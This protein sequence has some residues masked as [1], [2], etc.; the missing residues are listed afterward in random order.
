MARLVV[1]DFAPLNRSAHMMPMLRALK[2]AESGAPIRDQINQ[3]PPDM[4]RRA[5]RDGWSQP[6]EGLAPVPAFVFDDLTAHWSANATTV[7]DSFFAYYTRFSADQDGT[8]CSSAYS[9][10]V[11]PAVLA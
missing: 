8:G 4:V 5:V 6:M 3:S 7:A 10:R 1:S 11:L 9:P 2:S